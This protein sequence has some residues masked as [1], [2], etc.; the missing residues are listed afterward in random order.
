MNW[1][2]KIIGWFNPEAAAKR[3]AWRQAMDEQRSYDAGSHNRVNANWRAVNQSAEYTDR[4]YRDIVRA[5]ARDLERNSDLMNSV[6]GPFVRN[7]VGIWHY[8]PSKI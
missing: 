5:R 8:P 4:Y 7:V 1:L 3:E 6:I 2:D